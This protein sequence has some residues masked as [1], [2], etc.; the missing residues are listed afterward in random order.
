MSEDFEAGLRDLYTRAADAHAQGSGF[1]TTAM[2]ATA[3]RNRRVRRGAVAV[4]TAAA[5]VGVGLG[6]AAAVRQLG[7]DGAAP[8]AGDGTPTVTGTVLEPTCGT[9]LADLKVVEGT[10]TTFRAVPRETPIVS[11][12][13]LDAELTLMGDGAVMSDFSIAYPA[14]Y[15]EDTLYLVV[16]DGTVVGLGD[17]TMTSPA[18]DEH[19]QGVTIT[20]DACDSPF[21]RYPA[22]LVPGEYVLYPALTLVANDSGTTVLFLGEPAPFTVIDGSTPAPTEPDGPTPDPTSDDPT[23]D[24]AAAAP[25]EDLVHDVSATFTE[26]APL[27]DG[28]YL[29][30]LV[31]VDGEASTVDVDLMVWYSGQAA[32]DYVAANVAGGEVVNDYY[33]VNDSERPTTLPIAGDALVSEWCFGD[34]EAPELTYLPRT[35]PE[36]AAASDYDGAEA[37]MSCSDG[38]ELDRGWL[39]WLRVVDGVV[40]QVTGQFVP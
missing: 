23:T 21:D 36:W 6:G 17:G 27:A 18:D 16:Q 38:P 11:G 31:G 40:V 7:D 22:P 28:D 32:E 4:M 20:V 13:P 39:Y 15:P 12:V 30:Q 33:V 19:G 8:P 25:P 14:R 5:V 29:A 24:D 2:V 3:R 10:G 9:A 26:G 1:P 37:H 35:V 34:T